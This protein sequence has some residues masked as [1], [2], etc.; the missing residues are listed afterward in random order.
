MERLQSNR[1]TN[2]II[3]FV[4]LTN[5]LEGDCAEVGAFKGGSALKISENTQKKVWVFELFENFLDLNENDHPSLNDMFFKRGQSGDDAYREMVDGFKG[6]NVEVVKGYFP[7]SFGQRG[8]NLKFSFVHLDTDVY[9]STLKSL[10][11]F[12]P[13][14]P[15]GGIILLHDYHHQSI[16]VKKACDLFFA[17]KPEKIISDGQVNTD[18][19]Q[20]YIVKQ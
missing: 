14:V 16:T 2:N 4:N 19:S 5:S 6:R 13:K 9:T 10:E 20:G 18:M 11:Y 1:E 7:D 17:D 12:Y 15:K 8:D 3:N